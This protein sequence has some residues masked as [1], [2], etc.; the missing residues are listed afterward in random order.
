MWFARFAATRFPPNPAAPMPAAAWVHRI[1]DELRLSD[2]SRELLL[3]RFT[4]PAAV[5]PENKLDTCEM[6]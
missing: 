6:H 1:A 3:G 5:S 2:L 4:A